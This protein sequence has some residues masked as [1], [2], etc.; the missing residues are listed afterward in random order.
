MVD[1]LFCRVSP[2]FLNRYSPFFKNIALELDG[3]ELYKA[4]FKGVFD[5]K[6]YR[7]FQ[8]E[9]D[10][11]NFVEAFRDLLTSYK[12]PEKHT[13]EI[14]YFATLIEDEHKKILSGLAL[15]TKERGRLLTDLIDFEKGFSHQNGEIEFEF[16]SG[17]QYIND[18]YFVKKEVIDELN[19]SRK[20]T[21]RR[22]SS[23]R[24]IYNNVNSNEEIEI[25]K[26]ITITISSN[27]NKGQAIKVTQ[28]DLIEAMVIALTNSLIKSQADSNTDLYQRLI[29]SNN[30]AVNDSSLAK[31]RNEVKNT[32]R[33]PTL[34]ATMSLIMLEYLK[35]ISQLKLTQRSYISDHQARFLFDFFALTG[36]ISDDCDLKEHSK[37]S[38]ALKQQ[39]DISPNKYIQKYKA[40]RKQHK[41]PTDRRAQYIRGAIA[42]NQL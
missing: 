1:S 10:A 40:H 4:E 8:G 24:N 31:K 42:D 16:P 6:V 37:Y 28:P 21:M 9:K 17:T 23:I 29:N 34:I 35:T 32:L 2:T 41:N 36:L 15:D 12:I 3:V 18:V 7:S 20:K 30:T 13:W 25:S 14:F 22:W 38:A 39:E 27:L 26:D 5:G 19:D 33:L 11:M